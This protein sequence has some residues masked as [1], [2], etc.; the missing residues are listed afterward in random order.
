M[1]RP[2]L[3][4]EVSDY[5]HGRRKH[6]HRCQAC[7]RIVQ[8]GQAV[9]MVRLRKATR[10][11]HLGEA[12]QVMIDGVTYREMFHV[13][14]REIRNPRESFDVMLAAVRAELAPKCHV[15]SCEQ[16]AGHTGECGRG[17]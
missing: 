8:T 10:V 16:H 2:D 1:K 11:V 13:W 5:Q 3:V 14:A 9:L 7:N 4:F 15:P 6:R 17:F 12:D